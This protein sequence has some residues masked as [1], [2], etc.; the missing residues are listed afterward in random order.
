MYHDMAIYGCISVVLSLLSH[1]CTHRYAR[2]YVYTHI[3]CMELTFVAISEKHSTFATYVLINQQAS[4]FIP[5][6]RLQY[7]EFE[8]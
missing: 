7:S 4:L 1:I 3:I 6:F 5:L 8:G 2:M